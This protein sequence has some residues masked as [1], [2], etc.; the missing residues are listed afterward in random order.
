M[1]PPPIRWIIRYLIMAFNQMG[2]K[3]KFPVKTKPDKLD[4]GYLDRS[5]PPVIDFA[6]H[7]GVV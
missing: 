5:L 1:K 6:R 3:G 4:G 2:N 7:G